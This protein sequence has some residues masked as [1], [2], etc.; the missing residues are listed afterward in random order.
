[1]R[2]R[3][4]MKRP[5]INRSSNRSINV[6]VH[7]IVNHIGQGISTGAINYPLGDFNVIILDRPEYELARD[8][9]GK[10]APGHEISL[11]S[12]SQMGQVNDAELAD[13]YKRNELP[14]LDIGPAFWKKVFE[15]THFS[16]GVNLQALSSNIFVCPELLKTRAD[17]IKKDLFDYEG[18]NC[19]KAYA[20]MAIIHEIGHHFL[21][22]DLPEKEFDRIHKIGEDRTMTEGMANWFAYSL[23]TDIEKAVLAQSVT[24][25]TI[26]Y[27]SYLAI[28]YMDPSEVLSCLK[29]K[30]DYVSA[31]MAFSKMV[32][33]KVV[34]GLNLYCQ[35][36]IKTP[37]TIFMD[38]S[39]RMEGM[40][41]LV[42][43]E[44]IEKLGPVWGHVI[45]PR[46]QE[47]VGRF[48][49]STLIICNSIGRHPDYLK[50]PDNIRVNPNLDISGAIGRNPPR[51]GFSPQQDILRLLIELKVESSRLRNLLRYESTLKKVG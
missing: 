18:E 13:F 8:E 16:F 1:M 7:Q 39:V 41:N 4:N 44:E 9:L 51:E 42:V 14:L 24:D 40:F 17:E 47:L 37:G 36:S 43:K 34:G 10:L 23:A 3:Y 28:R 19:L 25:R 33:G 2:N 38:D 49:S 15:P 30:Y 21:Y 20:R 48:P 11:E 6:L 32:G 12:Y 35:G 26:A 45:T 22:G 29:E 50:L 27:R 31:V 46:I 5:I